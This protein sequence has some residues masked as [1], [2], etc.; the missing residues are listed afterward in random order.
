MVERDS[1]EDHI[2]EG[3]ILMSGRHLQHGDEDQADRNMEVFTNCATACTSALSYYNLLN[4]AGVGRCY[5]D[6]VMVVDWD[7][8]P[9]LVVGT[10]KD[11]PDIGSA[12]DLPSG[13][14][15]VLHVVD[16]SRE[17]WAKALEIYE[18][19]TFLM[20]PDYTLVLDF[21][22]V[23]P[24]GEPIKGMQGRPSCGPVPTMEAFKKV[25]DNVVGVG[26]PKWKQ[27][28]YVD[29]YFADS[30]LVGGAR[31]AARIAIKHW[32][33]PDIFEFIK[34][35]AGGDLWSANNS[36]GVD[37]E[38]WNEVKSNETADFVL[39]ASR[40]FDAITHQSYHGGRGEPGFLNLHKLNANEDG[41]DWDELKKGKFVGSHKYQVE[42]KTENL[43]GHI[44]MRVQRKR[45]KF[46]CNPCSEIVLSILGGFCVIGDVVPHHC[47]DMKEAE[48]A[49][50]CTVRALIRTNTMDSIYKGE[51]QRTNRVGVGLTGIHEWMWEQFIVSF[52]SAC[53]DTGYS[54]PFWNSLAVLRRAAEDEA[55][56]YSESLGLT[57]PHT[58]TTIKPAGTTSKLFGLSEGCHLPAMA[59]YM[60]WVQFK[61]DDPLVDEYRGHGY[62]IKELTTFKG[63]VA[64][65]FPTKPTI[66]DL[67]P[68]LHLV[69]ADDASIK[70]QFTWL[71]RLEHYWLGPDLG[72]QLS[73]TLNFQPKDVSYDEYR[74]MMLD[75]VPEVRCVSILPIEDT[76]AHEYLPNEKITKEEYESWMGR[77]ESWKEDIGIDHVQCG[78]GG[79]PITF[80]EG[81]LNET[82]T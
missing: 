49:V 44:A 81:D 12:M 20:Q 14:D 50:R 18:T 37:Q 73:Y 72:N 82:E 22:N 46:I 65:G 52:T 33:D 6:D 1:L 54:I 5:D 58:V 66:T 21:C 59:Y 70:D 45:H 8:A 60:R 78:A 24:S 26:W 13:D 80:T 39:Y 64:V 48:D 55:E 2:A 63:M 35:K 75:C 4:G 28:M 69:T 25:H 36:V 29:H 17:G 51:V 77:I 67:I 34:I 56:R 61:K 57:T 42:K 31:R 38:F 41:L 53:G 10:S 43:L 19:M 9:N 40:V 27:A 16:D 11:H 71:S 79:C 3:R 15:V 76:S 62:P 7:N 23:R 68:D 32:A 30:V 47:K 74:E